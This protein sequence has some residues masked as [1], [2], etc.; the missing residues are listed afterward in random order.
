MRN[1]D[2]E[3]MLPTR[4]SKNKVIADHSNAHHQGGMLS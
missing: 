4:G 1:P 3:T 2:Q